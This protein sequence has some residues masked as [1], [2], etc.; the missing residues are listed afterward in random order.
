MCKCA[1][2]GR[3]N[4]WDRLIEVR[5]EVDVICV[6]SSNSK[7]KTIRV[8]CLPVGWLVKL[9]FIRGQKKSCNLTA[10]RQ[11]SEISFHSWFKKGIRVIGEI[12]SHSW[13]K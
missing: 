11:V 3:G 5:W 4:K 6:I 1:K 13:S 7:F 9:V 2:R 12:S 10:V 8:T